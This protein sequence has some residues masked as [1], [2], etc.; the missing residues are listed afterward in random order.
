MLGN[1]RDQI[2]LTDSAYSVYKKGQQ[3]F[4]TQNKTQCHDQPEKTIFSKC[5]A[6][7][8]SSV[9][10]PTNGGVLF[11]FVQP[12]PSIAGFVFT[13]ATIY[14]DTTVNTYDVCYLICDIIMGGF[15]SYSNGVNSSVLAMIPLTPG[16]RT[17]F[18]NVKYPEVISGVHTT[19]SIR[20]ELR[21]RTNNIIKNIPYLVTL[22]FLI[23]K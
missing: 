10:V 12:N 3:L 7:F 1:E 4:S 22:T 11:N 17:H 13:G 15:P 23:S 21:D 16:V 8:D 5:L 19:R 2:S 6:F 18:Y 14:N 9:G 20:F